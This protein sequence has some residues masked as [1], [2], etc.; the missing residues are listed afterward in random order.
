MAKVTKINRI[1]TI[2]SYFRTKTINFAT[3]NDKTTTFEMPNTENIQTIAIHSATCKLFATGTPTALLIQ[4]S[5]RHEEKNDGIRNEIRMLQKLC[6]RDFA[7]C[8]FDTLEWAKALMPWHDEAVSHDVEVGI[9]AHE[10][11]QY[12]EH[13]LLPWLRAEYGALPCVLGGYSLGGLFALWASMQTDAFEAVAAASPSL[14]IKG[15]NEYAESHKTQAHRIFLSLGKT[16]EHCRNQR[17]A[18]I[19]DCVRKQHAT[20]CRQIGT[21]NTTLVWNEGGHFGHEAERMAQAFGFL[22]GN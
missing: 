14:W 19:G 3:V 12:V 20:L 9:H 2:F 6:H 4:P 1:F 22:V 17:M 16:E 8:I 13:R 18:R 21:D 15:W 11:L 7:I 10:T 5:A